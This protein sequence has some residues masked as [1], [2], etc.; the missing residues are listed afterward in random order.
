MEKDN[1]KHNIW[2][3]AVAISSL[4]TVV[5][6]ITFFFFFCIPGKS[7]HIFCLENQL[8]KQDF[9]FFFRSVWFAHI[10]WYT[11]L[12]FIT[13]CILHFLLLFGETL[14]FCDSLPS[15]KKTFSLGA[16][17][18]CRGDFWHASS[19]CSTFPITYLRTVS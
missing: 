8:S 16:S 12:L 18:N 1:P 11:F 10:C 5:Y 3:T 14:K 19:L 7:F 13:S 9:Y 15:Q 4:T 2:R 17:L 6:S